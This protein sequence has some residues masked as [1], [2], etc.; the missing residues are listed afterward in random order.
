M[1]TYE[2]CLQD[3]RTLE[4]IMY[5][6][7]IA[8]VHAHGNI[9][10]VAVITMNPTPLM[11]LMRISGDQFVLFED[12]NISLS[13]PDLIPKAR[14]IIKE[15]SL[16]LPY[17]E[18]RNGLQISLIL[19][20]LRQSTINPS[21][22]IRVDNYSHPMSVYVNQSPYTGCTIFIIDNMLCIKFDS[23]CQEFK[24]SLSDP[25]LIKKFKASFEIDPIT[26]HSLI[27]QE[28]RQLLRERKCQ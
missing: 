26:G 12:D 24:V 25:E 19:S 5:D 3:F 10:D 20:L 17:K 15:R 14:S 11:I 16:G 4:H 7:D 2:K 18:P 27:E 1:N 22:D 21:Y 6:L 8:F 28:N 23:R 9:T 13:D